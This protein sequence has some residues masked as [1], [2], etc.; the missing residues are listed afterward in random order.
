MLADAVF[1]SVVDVSTASADEE[2]FKNIIGTLLSPNYPR[3]YGNNEKRVYKIIAPMLS[4]VVLIFDTFDVEYHEVCDRDSLTASTH[5]VLMC[6]K[7]SA[8]K[9]D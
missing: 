1:L 5:L 6:R 7:F 9:S 2:V 3:N 4:E 8:S